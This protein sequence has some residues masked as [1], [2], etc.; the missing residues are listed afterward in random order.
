[1]ALSFSNFSDPKCDEGTISGGPGSSPVAPSASST[2]FCDH[3]LTSVGSYS[4]TATDTATPPEGQGAPVTHTSNTVVVN[5]PSEP[6]FTI[7]KLQEIAGSSGGFTTS[8]LTGTVGQRVNYEIVV[9]NTGNVALTLSFS[10]PHCDAGTVTGPIGSLNLDGTLAAQGTVLYFCSHVLL[11][12]DSPQFTNTVT[13]T[14]QPP[15]GPPVGG[16]STVVVNVAQQAVAPAKQAVQAAC[17]VSEGSIVLRGASGAQRQP[18]T[19]RISALGIKQITFY[20][21]ARKLKTLTHAQAKNG[22]FTIKIDPRKLSFGAHRVSFKTTM[23]DPNCP[24][25][26]RAAVFVHPRPPVVRPKFTG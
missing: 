1:V 2:Y 10:D 5:V 23:S 20:L 9:K 14:G 22:Q 4:N 17:T 21:D 15:S 13:V 26:A 8:T 25:L 19:V 6:A 7:E 3:V 24:N 18:F 16:T 11:A 12:G